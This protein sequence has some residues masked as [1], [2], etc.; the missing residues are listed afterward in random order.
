M[1]ARLI[2]L[3]DLQPTDT[4]RESSQSY[5]QTLTYEEIEKRHGLPQVWK[6]DIGLLISDGNQRAADAYKKG[7]KE[8]RVDFQTDDIPDYFLDYLNLVISEAELLRKQGIHS[9]KDLWQA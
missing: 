4:L 6:T 2:N 5:L 1:P 9:P 7:L 8:I 3:E